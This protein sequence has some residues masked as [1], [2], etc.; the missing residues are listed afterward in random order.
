MIPWTMLDTVLCTLHFTMTEENS[1]ATVY[2][3][4]NVIHKQCIIEID[5]LYRKPN[6]N[7]YNNAQLMPRGW[8]K[9]AAFKSW[10]YRFNRLPP[11]QYKHKEHNT[12]IFI[13]QQRAVVAGN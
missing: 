10:L 13:S 5:M 1:D 9:I 2:L 3:N 12:I 7:R 11:E 6:Y 4:L 8:I